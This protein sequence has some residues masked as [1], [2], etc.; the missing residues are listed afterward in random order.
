M[1]RELPK[2]LCRTLSAFTL[3]EL[4]VVV[5]IIAILA[6]MLLPALQ[7]AREKARR[8]SCINSLGQI[9]RGME[10][11]LGDYDQ[12]YPS[13]IGIP[14]GPSDGFTWCFAEAN[15][16]TTPAWGRDCGSK[17]KGAV[18]RTPANGGQFTYSGR[19]GD[20][21]VRADSPDAYHL[22]YRTV[23]FC[24]DSSGNAGDLNVSPQ[25]LGYLLVCGYVGD[26]SLFYCPSSTGMPPDAYE[27]VENWAGCTV[28]NVTD[29]GQLG[30][31]DAKA[32]LYG[33]YKTPKNFAR[34]H[35]VV[36]QGSYH[37]RNTQLGLYNPWHMFE[38]NERLGYGYSYP[39]T[40]PGTNP[41]VIPRA[42]RPLFPTPKVLANRALVADTFSK[43]STYDA[44]GT[45][46]SALNDTAIAESRVI[47]GFGLK[48]HREGYNV[49]YGDGHA[50]WFGD[51]QQ[52]ITW[53]TQG[54]DGYTHSGDVYVNELGYS[55]YYGMNAFLAAY[56]KNDIGDGDVAHSAL[57]VWHD[58]DV[59]GGVDVGQ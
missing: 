5:A 29:W 15:E 9:G 17:H 56:H 54:R 52:K 34:G 21:P 58:L 36:V 40:I 25:G 8:A 2:S 49:L 50:Q 37:Y 32:M 7:A 22:G 47:A 23:A 26:V 4:L 38:E 35:N 51:P 3:I 13:W 1:L 30:G 24:Y 11:Y 6:A 19:P 41:R 18:S 39:Y 46:V 33:G 12:Y 16:D 42:N 44:N 14:G 57:A 48:G 53:H 59:A 55:Y 31:R 28:A 10:M 27:E 20:T 43:G 45:N